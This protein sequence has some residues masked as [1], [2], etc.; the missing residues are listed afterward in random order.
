MSDRPTTGKPSN[1]SE[2]VWRERILFLVS[3]LTAVAVL[4]T[5]LFVTRSEHTA[6][7]ATKV[8]KVKMEKHREATAHREQV[9]INK[10]QNEIN[11]TQAAM[12]A[13]V[14]KGLKNIEIILTEQAVSDRPLR[15][16][17][18]KAMLADE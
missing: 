5:T 3:I 18:I 11:K 6:D 12:N 15:R 10:Q 2:K 16:R 1:G 17:D 8:D 7:L 14:A 13:A 9:I 4:T